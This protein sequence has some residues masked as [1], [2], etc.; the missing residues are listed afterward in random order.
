MTETQSEQN[1]Q[2][3][4]T[5]VQDASSTAPAVTNTTVEA[6]ASASPVV[7]NNTTPAPAAQPAPVAEQAP[8][9]QQTENNA[10]K[11]EG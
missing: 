5:P 6:Q 7:E 1:V 3:P 2:T 11:K 10:E 9:A 8:T 4:V